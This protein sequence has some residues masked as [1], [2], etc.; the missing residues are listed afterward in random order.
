V[1]REGK[2]LEANSDD[3]K[4]RGVQRFN[5]MLSKNSN[6]TATI[7]STVGVKEFDGMA[8]AVVNRTTN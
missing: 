8:L 1:I 2:V 3:D 4:V 5:E 7:L 6:V